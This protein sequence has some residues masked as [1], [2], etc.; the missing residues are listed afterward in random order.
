MRK[1]RVATGVELLECRELLSVTM[2]LAQHAVKP[3]SVPTI[4]QIAAEADNPVVIPPTTTSANIFTNPPP[5]SVLTPNELKREQFYFAMSGK[6]IVG[7]GRFTDQAASIYLKTVGRSTY[8]LSGDMQVGITVPKDT[9]QPAQGN[10][11]SYDQNVNTNA[12]FSFDIVAVPGQLTNTAGQR[13]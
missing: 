5:G 6:Y 11:T 3:P 1:A 9:S 2:I 12:A 4:A 8:F 13:F 10:A 7:P